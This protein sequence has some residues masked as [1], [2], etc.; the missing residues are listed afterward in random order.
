MNPV[1]ALLA[2]KFKK[3]RVTINYKNLCIHKV[4]Q[5]VKTPVRLYV[6]VRNVQLKII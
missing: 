6:Y 1:Q 2:K 5:D 3:Q 4:C